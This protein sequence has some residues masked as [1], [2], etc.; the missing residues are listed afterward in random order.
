MPHRPEGADLAVKLQDPLGINLT[1]EVGHS[2][3]VWVDDE[4]SPEVADALFSYDVDSHTTGRLPYQLDPVL[5]GTHALSVEAWDGAN[6]R[7]R[8][9]WTLH[10]SLE[11][12]LDVSDLFNYP[13]PF[14]T[15]TEVVYTLSA[16]AEVEISVY[17]LNGVKVRSLSPGEQGHGFQR[18]PWDGRDH[19]GDQVANGAYLYRL[20]AQA[21]DGQTII[22]WGRLARL[23]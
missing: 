20:R 23:R 19:F 4:S 7:S 18:L 21:I 14:E 2:I 17:T 5:T 22:Q 1:G 9:S 3:R 13:N 12:E 8:A 16:P 10:L 11:E 6:N 15:F